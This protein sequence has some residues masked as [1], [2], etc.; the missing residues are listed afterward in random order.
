MSTDTPNIPHNPSTDPDT[1]DVLERILTDDH[2]GEQNAITSDELATALDECDAHDTNPSIRDACRDLLLSR[3]VPVA[4]GTDGYWIA[5]DE[6]E[7]K[8]EIATIREKIGALNHRKMALDAAAE[9]WDFDSHESDTG[10]GGDCERCGGAIHGDAWLWY[11]VELC[12]DCYEQKPPSES[13][14]R[15]W[16]RGDADE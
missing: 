7:L 13:A 6:S 5:A 16:V 14:F 11:S 4:S 1:L 9:G 3:G 8:D 10:E 12:H 15:A 2:V